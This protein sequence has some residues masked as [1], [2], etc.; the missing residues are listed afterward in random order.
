MPEEDGYSMIKRLR[1]CEQEQGTQRVPAVA[2]TAF[3]REEDRQCALEA[4][5]DDHLPK[6]IDPEGL[7][8]A[9]VRL[10]TAVRGTSS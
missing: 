1:Q 4:G 2:V 10:V 7:V 6:P 3:A 5:F 8:S 9:V